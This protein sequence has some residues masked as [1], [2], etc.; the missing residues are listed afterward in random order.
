MVEVTSKT[1][2]TRRG[3]LR[4]SAI[5]AGGAV[6]AGCSGGSSGGSTGATDD[7]P[8]LKGKGS[9]TGPLEPPSTFGE[10]PSL[11]GQVKA[12]KL[13]PVEKRLPEKPYVVPHNWLEI[14]KYGGVLNMTQG[15]NDPNYALNQNMYGHSILRFLNDG[16]D[17]GPGLAEEWEASED[18][19]VWTFHFRKGLRWSDG[20]PWT[21]ADIMYWWED[22]VQNPDHEDVPPDDVRSGRDTTA[23]LTAPDDYTLVLTFDAPAPITAERLA[24]Y[25]NGSGNV[26]PRWMAPK[27]YLQQFHPTYNENVG[28]N[29]AEEHEVKANWTLNPECPTMCGWRTKSYENGR[30]AIFER[31]PYYWAVDKEGNQLPY[32]DELRFDLI[33]DEQVQKAEILNGSY[34]FVQGYVHA[35]FPLKD[36]EPL[37]AQERETGVLVFFWDSGTGTGSLLMWNHDYPKPE[38]RELFRNKD[39]RR[40][41]SYAYNRKDVRKAI[42]YNSGELTTGTLSPKGVIFQNSDEGKQHFA[43]WRDSYVQY[44]PN[45]AK[46][47][48]DELGLKDTDGDGF[49]EFP[50][51]DKLVLYLDYPAD[52]AEEHVQ[53]NQHVKRDWEAVGIRADLNPL[54]Q[55]SFGDRWGRGELMINSAWEI[56]DNQP[57]I[58]PGW[59][60]PV[61][62]D[63]WAPL[64]GAA[65]GLQISDPGIFAKQ[66]RLSPWERTPPWLLPESDGEPIARLWDLYNRARVEIDELERIRL[67][68]EV[69]KIHVEEGPFLL[70]VV[71][72]T[73]RIVLA[74]GELRNVPRSENLALGGWTNPWFLPSPAAYDPETFYWSTPAAHT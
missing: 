10:A 24:A 26:G 25:V 44:D 42:Y 62:D 9:A 72:N 64:H 19:K 59:V 33:G 69:V 53:K 38:Y 28:K 17:I 21:T 71:A 49:R 61:V 39:F 48:L 22:L 50:N 67:L 18:A 5:L 16:L 46:A 11:A 74:H 51:G 70:G 15:T 27:H 3:L 73:P 12:G 30:S 36:V 7:G 29:W 66:E 43:E 60:I 6:L 40:A 57:M 2:W 65:Y 8:T 55:D 58:Y 37:R 45:Q 41:L 47:M 56:G 68:W 63:H 35:P 31:N 34:D 23:K 54:P 4:A 20:A 14:G 52:T 32:I 1:E 13:D